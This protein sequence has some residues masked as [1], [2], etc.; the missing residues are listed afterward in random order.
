MRP[1]FGPSC[2]TSSV[3]LCVLDGPALYTI[4]NATAR[5]LLMVLYLPPVADPD[6]PVGT[7]QLLTSCDARP[8]NVEAV[9]LLGD[10]VQQ[11]KV[12][13][14]IITIAPVASLM[15]FC[16]FEDKRDRGIGTF[17]EK[18]ENRETEQD[19]LRAPTP[20]RLHQ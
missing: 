18:V 1:R 14:C 4:P 12:Q 11:G 20:T 16:C 10:E 6:D 13:V 5:F 19:P 3:K 7:P 17:T 8:T 2:A 9:D 15:K